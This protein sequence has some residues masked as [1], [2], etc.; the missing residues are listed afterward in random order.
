MHHL[1]VLMHH[2]EVIQVNDAF[3]AEEPHNGAQDLCETRGGEESLKG[4]QVCLAESM[5]RGISVL[6][7]DMDAEVYGLFN[8]SNLPTGGSLVLHVYLPF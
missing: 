8:T 4:R 6:L 1:F 7:M 2:Q 5:V 3:D